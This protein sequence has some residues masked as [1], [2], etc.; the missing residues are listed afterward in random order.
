MYDEQG[1]P[2]E[3]YEDYLGEIRKHIDEPAPKVTIKGGDGS[4]FVSNIDTVLRKQNLTIDEFNTLRLKSVSELSPD[5]IAKMKAIRDSV[6]KINSSTVIK[7]TIPASDIEKYLGEKGYSEIGGYIAKY[8]DVSHITGYDNVVESSRL[9]YVTETGIRPYPEGGD[10]Y[11]Y[12]KFTTEDV[13]RIEIPYG[14]V[15]GGKNTDTLPCTLNGFTG[16]RNGEIIPEWTASKR[17]TPDYGSELHK[18]V[19][20]TDSIIGVFDGEHFR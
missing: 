11:G 7:K 15:F 18:V 16:A 19:N 9:D 17:L 8:D 12:I 13:N 4:G 3:E 5:E 6:P 2:C 20:G 1:K 10:A 14:K